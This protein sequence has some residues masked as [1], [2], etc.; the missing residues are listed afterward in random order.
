[1]LIDLKPTVK[2]LI[3][4][5]LSQVKSRSFFLTL[6][7]R[8]QSFLDFITEIQSRTDTQYVYDIEAVL[9][10][11][12]SDIKESVSDIGS[13]NR[14]QTLELDLEKFTYKEIE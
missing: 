4:S 12:G 14:E 8:N 11:G 1:M 3:S 13:C 5:I 6:D 9:I 7:K 10:R 2:T